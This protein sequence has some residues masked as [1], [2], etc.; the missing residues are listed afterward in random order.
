MLAFYD[1]F[2]EPNLQDGIRFYASGLVLENHMVDD[3]ATPSGKDYAVAYIDPWGEL[4]FE[5]RAQKDVHVYAI[6]S[7]A[8]ETMRR[9]HDALEKL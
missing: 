1:N 6:D 2:C 3:A 9:A 7:H 8:W 5:W 4:Q